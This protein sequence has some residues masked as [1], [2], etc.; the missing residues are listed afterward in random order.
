M[1][2]QVAPGASG[3][4]RPPG[5]PDVPG[6]LPWGDSDNVVAPAARGE[7]RVAGH[8]VFRGAVDALPAALRDAISR[9]VQRLAVLH[10]HKGD[11]AATLGNQVHFPIGVRTRRSRMR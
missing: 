3:Q 8:P 4:S 5:V 7:G 9:Q 1:S 2:R 11:H 6:Q 10:F